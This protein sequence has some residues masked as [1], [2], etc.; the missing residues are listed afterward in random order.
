MQRLLPFTT[1]SRTAGYAPKAVYQ[2][3][4]ATPAELR[5]SGDY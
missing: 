4:T 1:P 3:R 2:V 5:L